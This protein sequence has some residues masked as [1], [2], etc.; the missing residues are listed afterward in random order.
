MKEVMS[1]NK[2]VIIAVMAFISTSFSNPVSAMDKKSDPPGVE[3]KYLGFLDKNPVF[4]IVFTNVQVDNYYVT[5]KGESGNTLYS[6]KISGKNI[7]RR[8]RID[9]EEEISE[10]GLRFEIRT[11]TTNKTEVYTAGI[12][13]NITREMAVNKIQ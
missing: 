13:E 9:T 7:S 4:E 5:I 8:Y 10:G 2:A 6:E 12:N 1:K 11:G 3:I